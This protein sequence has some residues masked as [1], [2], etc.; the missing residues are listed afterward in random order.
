MNNKLA[1]RLYKDFPQLFQERS[2]SKR[3]SLMSFGIGCGD[4]WEPLLRQLCEDIMSIPDLDPEIAFAQIKEKFAG[5]TVYP[6]QAGRKDERVRNLCQTVWTKSK[7]YCEV[8][9]SQENVQEC[10]PGWI[11]TL[12]EEC[13]K[14]GRRYAWR[15][16][17]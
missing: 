1:S 14:T 7:L 4:G 5:L 8:C 3:V 13:F 15:E 17:E 16:D 10:G 6:N 2:Y 9:G 12:C 11:K